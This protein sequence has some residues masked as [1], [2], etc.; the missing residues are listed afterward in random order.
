MK[1]AGSPWR[2]LAPRLGACRAVARVAREGGFR[3]AFSAAAFVALATPA[4][5]DTPIVSVWYRGLP[6]GQ[7][8]LDDLAAIKALGFHGCHLAWRRHRAGFPSFGAW[9]RSSG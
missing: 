4:F 6:A 5:A 3:A 7:P 9:L 2:T 8:R 1:G